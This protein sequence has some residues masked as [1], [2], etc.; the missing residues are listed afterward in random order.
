MYKI[1]KLNW[2]TLIFSDITASCLNFADT[3]W[4]WRVQI[5]NVIYWNIG[6]YLENFVIKLIPRIYCIRHFLQ[7]NF[8][9]QSYIFNDVKVRTLGRPFH[10]FDFVFIH[11]CFCYA[12][13]MN[14]S[15]V[16]LKTIIII[17]EMPNNAWPQITVQNFNVFYCI[18]CSINFSQSTEAI[19]CNATSNHDIDVIYDIS[20]CS[21]IQ[22]VKWS[23]I[24]IIFPYFQDF[25]IF[26][27]FV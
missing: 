6:P 12:S 23:Y 8:H 1:Y 19:V 22:G 4:N 11:K 24:S 9:F 26:P 5:S 7:L 17:C 25:A 21:L 27:I 13:S 20:R 14:R 2:L 16:I 3:S 10:G 15:I 18:Y